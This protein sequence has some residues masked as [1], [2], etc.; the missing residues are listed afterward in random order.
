MKKLAI[1]LAALMGTSLV[2]ENVVTTA[3]EKVET[4]EIKAQIVSD[5]VAEEVKAEEAKADEKAAETSEALIEVDEKAAEIKVE[6]KKEEKVLKAE[7]KGDVSTVT[8]TTREEIL[9]EDLDIPDVVEKPAYQ[10]G[11]I[12]ASSLRVRAKAGTKYEVVSILK[13]DDEVKVFQTKDKWMEIQAPEKTAAWVA[14]KFVENGEIT[15][16][17]VKVRAGSGIV[18]SEIGRVSKGDKV[19]VLQTK[20]NTWC[21]IEAQESFRVWVGAD[22]VEIL[23]DEDQF[24][25]KLVQIEKEKAADKAK[26]EAALKAAEDKHAAIDAEMKATEKENESKVEDKKAPTELKSPASGETVKI[27]VSEQPAHEI[28]EEEQKQVDEVIPPNGLKIDGTILRVST[29]EHNIVNFALAK[30]VNNSYFP[31]C[32]LKVTDESQ[33]PGLDKLY[34]KEVEIIGVQKFVKG[35]KLPVIFVDSFKEKK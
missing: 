14:K 34:L 25:E 19:K 22:Y 7:V 33:V 30:K 11:R 8:E 15:A 16:D 5:K 26:A 27:P 12:T 32:Y 35:W 21:K 1:T 4:P 6:A 10:K 2:A 18:F 29:K 31:L 13:R 23:K 17:G 24:N 9:K 28:N 3:E 20:N